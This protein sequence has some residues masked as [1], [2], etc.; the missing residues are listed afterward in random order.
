M[1]WVSFIFIQQK[2]PTYIGVEMN[3]VL[4]SCSVGVE[5]PAEQRVE[6]NLSSL[7]PAATVA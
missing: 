6:G 7:R 2:T 3:A 4:F 1:P 5:T